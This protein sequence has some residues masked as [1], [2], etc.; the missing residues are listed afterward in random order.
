MATD[1]H[2]IADDL[3][4]DLKDLKKGLKTRYGLTDNQLRKLKKK[5]LLKRIGPVRGGYWQV[6]TGSKKDNGK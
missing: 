2:I 3:K 6:V 4:S 5:G 1:K